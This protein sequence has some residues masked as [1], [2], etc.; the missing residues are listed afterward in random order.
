MVAYA[1]PSEILHVGSTLF[2][3]PSEYVTSHE[4]FD[5]SPDVKDETPEMAMEDSVGLDAVADFVYALQQK[6]AV[7]SHAVKSVHDVPLL[8]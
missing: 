6:L 8:L 1:P 3:D 4:N 5:L 7:E 2:F